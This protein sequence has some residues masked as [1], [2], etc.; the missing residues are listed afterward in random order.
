MFWLQK[1]TTIA[2]SDN[3]MTIKKVVNYYYNIFQEHEIKLGQCPQ[4]SHKAKFKFGVLS[5]VAGKV[6]L[7]QKLD[8]LY[9][10]VRIFLKG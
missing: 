5:Y 2:V 8:A 4:G 6:W 7:K 1:V 9:D 3:F 10:P